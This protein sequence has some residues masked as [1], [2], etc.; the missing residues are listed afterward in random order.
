M[1]AT[2]LRGATRALIRETAQ[3][4]GLLPKELLRLQRA[5]SVTA[6]S[7]CCLHLEQNPD[8]PKLALRRKLRRLR[9]GQPLEVHAHASDSRYALLYSMINTFHRADPEKFWS[10]EPVPPI[11]DPLKAPEMPTVPPWTD[12]FALD[13]TPVPQAAPIEEPVES[14]VDHMAIFGSLPEQRL[15]MPA[16]RPTVPWNSEQ[17]RAFNSVFKWLKDGRRKPV[18]RLFG[19]AGTG[20][21]T[22][23]REIAWHV[24]GNTSD[25]IG[26]VRIYEGPKGEVLYS[27]FTG[28]ASS[29]LRSKGCVGAQTIHSLIYRPMIDPVTGTLV[30]TKVNEESPLK[31]AKLLIVDEVSMVNEE[32]AV[33]LMSF[34]VPILVLGDPGQLDPIEGEGYFTKGK[35]DVMLTKIERQAAENP[36]IYLAT[37]AREGKRLKVGRYGDSRVTRKDISDEQVAAAHM[38][39]TGMRFTRAA[40]NKRA[41]R[42]NGRYFIDAQYPVKGDNLMCLKNNKTSGLLNGTTWTCSDTVIKP[43]MKLKD[44]RRPLLGW[45]ETNIEGLHF[46]V[47]SHDIFDTEG[48]PIIINTICSTHHFDPSLPKPPWRE[49]AGTDEWGFG[50]AATVHKAQGSQWPNVLLI[51]ESHVFP[52]QVRKHQYTGITRAS[53]IITIKLTD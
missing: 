50:D 23:A 26:V 18:F 19:Y 37:L 39:L 30:G 48:S 33:D 31:Y 49:I 22:M 27:A 53:E 28:K 6:F 38:I 3:R 47:R 43:I 45:E 24:E 15:M 17:N 32:M 34:G 4:L 2:K 8:K 40:Y 36:I 7:A 9:L 14:E 11:A 35:P 51:D 44:F 10:T 46:K 16:A 13:A 25:G 5:L 42:I 1:S 20:K 52:T 41:R 12:P 29:V 21:T